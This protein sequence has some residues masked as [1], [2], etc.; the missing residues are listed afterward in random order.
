M[1]KDYI[2]EQSL[3][4]AQITSLHKDI[5]ETQKQNESILS[6]TRL[7]DLDILK[8]KIGLTGVSGEGVE[9]IL[10]DSPNVMRDTVSPSDKNIIHASDLRDIVNLLWANR[11]DAIAINS[12]RVIATTSINAVGSSIFVNNVYIVPPITITAIINPELFET[13]LQDVNT[14]VDLKIRVTKKEILFAMGAKSII[15][16][17]IYT[18]DFKLKKIKLDP[19]E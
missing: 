17:P 16:T 7:S 5:E 2:D 15:V 6:K 19:N 4:Q 3:Y 11:A 18:G 8:K 1:I 12:Q 9:I 10:K 13:R 14:L